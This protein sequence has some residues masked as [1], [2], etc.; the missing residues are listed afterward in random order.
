MYAENGFMTLYRGAMIN[1]FAGSIANAIF[2]SVYADGKRRY[3]KEGDSV[4]GLNTALV[5]LRAGVV[6][7]ICTTP[8]WVVKTRLAL[9]K[10][11]E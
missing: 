3:V 9:Y 4:K 8:M 7:M 1:I 6:S 11:Q 10:E 5:S 2:F